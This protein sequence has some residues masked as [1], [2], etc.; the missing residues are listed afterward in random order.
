MLPYSSAYA[1]NSCDQQIQ[2]AEDYFLQAKY[3]QALIDVQTCLERDHVTDVDVMNAYR[4][5]GKI[6]MSQKDP[7]TGAW[8][9]FQAILRL[10]PQLELHPAEDAPEVIRVFNEAK[11][12]SASQTPKSK[13]KKWPWYVGAA[14]VVGGATYLLLNQPNHT[15]DTGTLDITINNP[16]N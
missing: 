6:L 12:A 4:L 14:G 2:K 5:M 1:Q 15:P 10:N 3:E 9:A 7:E 8:Y 13:S 11:K 16:P